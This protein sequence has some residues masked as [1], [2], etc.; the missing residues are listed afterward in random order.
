MTRHIQYIV[1]YESKKI[2]TEQ[3]RYKNLQV[4]SK[5]NVIRKYQLAFSYRRPMNNNNGKKMLFNIAASRK[6]V[7]TCHYDGNWNT[8]SELGKLL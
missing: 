5:I 4:R 6:L 1:I 2:T 3:T 8:F 7:F